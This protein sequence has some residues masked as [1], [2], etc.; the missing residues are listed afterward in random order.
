MPIDLDE[1]NRETML[2]KLFTEDE[3]QSLRT[4]VMLGITVNDPPPVIAIGRIRKK[5][6]EKGD[7]KY[8]KIELYDMMC[9]I[10]PIL[11]GAV[12]SFGSV[13]EEMFGGFKMRAGSKMDAMEKEV[14]K[15]A[16]EFILERRLK[17]LA[18]SW[19]KKIL[20]YGDAITEVLSEND[21]GNG[22]THVRSIPLSICTILEGE[23]QI[24]STEDSEDDKK[25]QVWKEGLFVVNEWD[26][27]TRETFPPENIIHLSLDPEESKVV[28]I[29]ERTTYNVWS[30]SP[31][32]PLET[33]ILW[34]ATMTETDILHRR[35][36]VPREHHQ[37][38]LAAFSPRFYTGTQASRISAAEAAATAAV[39]RYS[40][41]MK[42]I[43]PDQEYIT[44]K[45]TEI[46]IVEPKST[47][48]MKPNEQIA[49]V[50]GDITTVGASLVA[51]RG[52]KSYA[53]AYIAASLAIIDVKS[54]AREVFWGLLELV[55]RHLRSKMGK[56]HE[57]AIKNLQ[58]KRNVIFEQQLAELSSVVT[59]LAATKVY[60][61]DQ[62]RAKMGDDPL[63][64][65][66]KK[67][68][69][70][71]KKLV[72]PT[73]APV[74]QNRSADQV[75]R[76]VQHNPKTDPKPKYPTERKADREKKGK[77]KG[78]SGRK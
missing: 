23:H 29:N 4:S 11:R 20:R 59:A 73:P 18:F 60:T 68:L 25:A 16:E 36:V 22:V 56:S 37:L 53:T 74:N 41:S 71:Y 35:R 62:L 72:E 49:Q 39:G 31:I 63:T 57:K 75:K 55:R 24:Q 42:N 15:E 43:E 14:L 46:K 65:E 51:V 54:G 78:E 10:D 12:S 3:L 26:P 50:N 8:N 7:Q 34:K 52:E 6:E 1:L 5:M 64:D 48:Y 69:K 58:I 21:D 32:A 40:G 61:P 30:K 44:G 28:D 19:G 76:D 13:I 66:E 27:D 9:D 67:E 38:D 45:Q 47:N 33:D 70:E 2:S 17:R 77:R